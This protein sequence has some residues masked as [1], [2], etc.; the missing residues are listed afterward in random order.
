M[1]PRAHCEIRQAVAAPN[2]LRLRLGIFDDRQPRAH[3]ALDVAF[4]RFLG[5]ECGEHAVAGVLQDTAVVR[6][7]GRR[8]ALERAIHHGVDLLGVELLAHGG[9]ADH[10]DKQHRHL[11]ELLARGRP[12]LA[13]LGQLT[14]Q[15]GERRVDHGIAKRRPLRFE[16]SNGR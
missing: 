4:A 1:Q 7:H 6:P 15:G 13:Q 14:P 12:A 10:V 11:L 5:A 3:G 2:L 8:E 9:R 16:C